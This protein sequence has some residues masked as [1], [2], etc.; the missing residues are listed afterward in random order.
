[1]IVTID[2]PAGTGKSTVAHLLAKRL[3]LE[4]LDTGAMYRAITLLVVERGIDPNDGA[5]IAE[6]VRDADLRFDF[7]RSS[8]TGEPPRLFLGDR[9]VTDAVRSGA[10]TAHVSTV[11]GHAAVRHAMV[12]AQRSIADAHPR[13]VTEGR[14]QGSYVFPDADVK[15]YLDASPEIRAERRAEQLRAKGEAV[16]LAAIR[17]AIEARDRNDRARPF[18]ALVEPRDAIRVD[19]GALH[20]HAVVEVL[21]RSARGRIASLLSIGAPSDAFGGETA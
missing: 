5:C 17:A 6:I 20:V 13:L 9:D 11:A 12:G 3:G 1:V 21:E 16:D 14:D 15:F 8:R 4:F 7:D 18:G 2:G 19:T 10:V